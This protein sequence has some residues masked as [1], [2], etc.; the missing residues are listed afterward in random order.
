MRSYPCPGGS[1]A[2]DG[3]GPGGPAQGPSGAVSVERKDLY[4]DQRTRT[5]TEREVPGA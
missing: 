4:E 2:F 3:D 1:P 5:A